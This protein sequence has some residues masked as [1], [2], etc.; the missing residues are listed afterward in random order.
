MRILLYSDYPALFNALQEESKRYTGIELLQVNP[1]TEILTLPDFNF[2]VLAPLA[3]SHELG[4]TPCNASQ[5]DAWQEKTTALVDLCAL[6]QSQLTLLSS[7]G[8]FSHHQTSASELD[9]P[10][11]VTPL[12]KSLLMLEKTV[13]QL[14]QAIIL[15]T[16]PSLN[17][18]IVEIGVRAN[19][20]TQIVSDP[21]FAANFRGTQPLSDLAR[22]LLGIWLQLDAGAKASGLFHYAGSGALSDAALLEPLSLTTQHIM[23]VFG[24]HPRAWR[25]GLP[26][27]LESLKESTKNAAT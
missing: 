19:L 27:L 7:A 14:P 5:L 9:T 25:E 24:I 26:A 4:A 18:E 15:R 22:V 13:A 10:D 6:R 17:A 23:N 8:V 20:K 21:N 12:A 11:S 3:A 16:P 2:L 1:S